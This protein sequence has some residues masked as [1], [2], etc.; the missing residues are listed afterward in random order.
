MFD[1][2]QSLVEFIEDFSNLVNPPYVAPYLNND[3]LDNFEQQLGQKLPASFRDFLLLCNFDNLEL[4]STMFGDGSDGF[5]EYL[6]STNEDSGEFIKIAVGEIGG[7]FISLETGEIWA[8]YID[9]DITN[10]NK[11]ADNFEGFLGGYAFIQRN[12][13][14]KTIPLEEA[15]KLVAE[16][17]GSDDYRTWLHSVL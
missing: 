7:I 8:Q 15:A 5:L 16:K 1:S 17:I 3:K 14:E 9:G 11:L 4:G 2:R 13:I 6:L 10:Q 12:R